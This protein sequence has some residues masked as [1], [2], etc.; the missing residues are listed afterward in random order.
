MNNKLFCYGTLMA[1][2]VFASVSGCQRPM[3]P[4]ALAGYRRLQMQGRPYPGLV[5]GTHSQVQGCLYDGVSPGELRRLDQYEGHWYK[6]C[7]VTV[8][9]AD[10]RSVRAWCYVIRRFHG[11]K[12]GP[13]DWELQQFREHHLKQALNHLSL[14]NENAVM[15]ARRVLG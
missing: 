8:R 13:T 1:P 10:N 6:R 4:A 2:E 9:C 5:R 12:L 3:E 7:L 14:R 11:N 15:S